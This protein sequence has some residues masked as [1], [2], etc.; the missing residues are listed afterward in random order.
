MGSSHQHVICRAFGAMLSHVTL[1]S[2]TSY[3][4]AFTVTLEHFILIRS[5]EYPY[6]E[7]TNILLRGIHRGFQAPSL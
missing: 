6:V 2:Q 1:L 3:I 7:Q 5:L 4:I